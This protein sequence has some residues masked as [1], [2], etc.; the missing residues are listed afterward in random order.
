M[1]M[2]T[3]AVFAGRRPPLYGHGHGLAATTLPGIGEGPL[4][5][6]LAA[7]PKGA[8]GK[9]RQRARLNSSGAPI[10]ARARD[11]VRIMMTSVKTYGAVFHRY[12]V[13]LLAR[14]CTCSAW[15]TE[16]TPP[17]SSAA[18]RQRTGSQ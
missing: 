11:E 16:L 12:A 1:S 4:G 10:M 8:S 14:F 3:S 9:A 5:N 18:N 15:A 6:P 2:T 13:A 7:S 17:N